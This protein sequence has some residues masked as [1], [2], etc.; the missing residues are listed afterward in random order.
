MAKR[1]SNPNVT[2]R[3]HASTRRW[4][5]GVLLA[6]AA[7]VA[8]TRA[9]SAEAP[10]FVVIVNAK[11]PKSSVRRDFLADAFL[12]KLTVWDHDEKIYPVDQRPSAPVRAAFSKSVLKRSVAAVRQYWLQRI[13]SGR[14]VPPPEVASDAQVVQ[15]VASHAG[16]VG[17]VSPSA[18]LHGVKVVQVR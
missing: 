5:L 8:P 11:N 9:G 13:F 10:E 16:A 3:R 6:F 18:T 14:D 12:K 7:S 15:F 17:Y 4:A 1:D 2:R